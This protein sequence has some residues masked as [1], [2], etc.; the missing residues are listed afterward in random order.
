MRIGPGVAPEARI[1]ALRV[2]GCQGS[3]NL[4][5]NAL[6]WAMDPNGDGDP[7]DRLDVV[8]L[9][10]GSDFGLPDTPDSRAADLLSQLGSL[11]VISAGNGGNQVYQAGSPG[12]STRA[13]TVANMVSSR[14]FDGI[15]VSGSSNPANDGVKPA[16]AAGNFSWNS[17]GTPVAAQLRYPAANRTGCSAFSPADSSA[18]SGRV[19]LLDWRSVRD[20]PQS[21]APCGS[22]Q[23]VDNAEAAGAVGV[24]IGDSDP[25]STIAI[26][27]N[28]TIP[29]VYVFGALSAALRGEAGVATVSFE[30]D[31]IG[32]IRV[33]ADPV[34][35]AVADSSS[36]GPGGSGV[37]KPDLA[38][39]G[40]DIVSS[41]AG[42]G[43]GGVAYS[44]T[45]MAAPHVA[46]MMALLRQAHPSWTSEELKALAMN[47]ARDNLFSD[48]ADP[49]VHQ[50]PQRVGT[51]TVDVQAALDAG[52]VAFASGGSGAVG[53]SFGPLQ[54]PPGVPFQREASITVVNKENVAKS[55]I[56]VALLPRSTVAG[57]VWSLPDGNTV[58]LPPNGTVQ[59]RVRLTVAD[60]SALRNDRDPTLLD[61]L[62]RDWIAETS[63]IVVL[64]EPGSRTTRV[65]VYASLAPASTLGASPAAL[66]L[67]A[68]QTSGAIDIRGQA[69]NTG[70][71]SNDFISL[72]TPLELQFSS[73]REPLGPNDPPSLASAD[74]R[75]VG[76]VYDADEDSLTFGAS[77]WADTPNPS[78]FSY[79]D[80][81]VD[82]TGDDKFDY[83][84][85]TGRD[86]DVEVGDSFGT[87]VKT[88][89][90]G[91]S[92]FVAPA[93]VTSFTQS[94]RVFDTDVMTMTVP[95]T[96]IG[97]SAANSRFTYAVDSG[98]LSD[99]R[100]VDETPL[101]S[102]DYMNPGLSFPGGSIRPDVAGALPFG[103]DADAMKANRSTGVLLLHHMNASGS[104]SEAIPVRFSE[105]VQVAISWPASKP[106]GGTVNLSAN[107][108]PGGPFTFDWDLGSGAFDVPGN[109][110]SFTP[111]DGPATVTI[112][113]RATGT[114]GTSSQ[115]TASSSVEMRVTNVPPKVRLKNVRGG[116]RLS[117]SASDRSVA[118]T[119]A[120]FRFA[121]DFRAD[122]RVDRRIRA[123][124]AVIAWPRGRKGRIVRVTAT[125][126]D[127]GTSIRRVLRRPVRR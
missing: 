37:L 59:I 56:P 99:G 119:R 102:F 43:D 82:A 46:G 72:L 97:L 111:D 34:N 114:Q 54:V 123:R 70:P 55:G 19:V 22:R 65:P 4:T 39:P 100:G 20:D 94:G 71:T 88:L 47:S 13:I 40:T 51:G 60:P 77:S 11:V 26:S 2:F 27:G 35:K 7:A 92:T 108:G 126:K 86:P 124:R 38:A 49:Q 18:I 14:L 76:V 52:T 95:R 101:L 57:A 50:P 3:S 12:A 112:A 21:P 9:S 127:G 15:R 120:G 24:V 1:H 81:Y 36:R 58:S 93:P 104:R 75:D 118:D 6:D 73:P 83:F 68:S 113:A 67:G 30:R 106:E 110:V 91:P 42:T 16:S 105:P 32:A 31:L 125:D 96:A 117:V 85:Y 63:G 17:L 115:G 122:G 41:E 53:V 90:S 5:V 87:I 28:S 23:R 107:A 80:V 64:T 62:N 66:D 44:G 61:G 103:F 25:N 45:S 33:E 109:P 69:V 48:P 78:D 8:N 10:L 98:L 121:I 84:I 89:P 74:L 79:H 29:S 116:R